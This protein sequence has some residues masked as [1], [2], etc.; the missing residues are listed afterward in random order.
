MFRAI[1]MIALAAAIVLAIGLYRAK[2]EAQAARFHVEEL[3]A[4]IAEERR[5]TAVLRAEIAYLERPE[6]LREL[7]E[8][9]LEM[10]AM[11]AGQERD[12]EE[13]LPALDPAEQEGLRRDVVMAG[14]LQE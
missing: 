10:D 7:A 8:R 11:Q 2:T 14:G 5:A 6:R 3:Q 4:Q 13:I 12:L 1:N 9:F